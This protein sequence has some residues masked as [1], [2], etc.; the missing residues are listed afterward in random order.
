MVLDG[1]LVG[2]TGTWPGLIAGVPYVAGS[3][4]GVT[5]ANGTFHYEAGGTIH[6]TLA[7]VSTRDAAGAAQLSPYQLAASG[8]CTGSSELD[9]LLQLLDSLDADGDLTNGIALGPQSGSPIALSALTDTDL[10]ARVD[11]LLPGRAVTLAGTAVDNFI[12]QFDAE[13][14]SEIGKDTFTGATAGVRS[15][16]CAYDGMHWYFSWQYGL[17]RDDLMFNV[18]KSNTVAIPPALALADGSNHIGGIDVL[19]GTLYAPVEDGSAYKHPYIVAYDTTGLTSGNTYPLSNTMLTQGVP[20]VAV[21]GPRQS[22]Y[23]AQWDPT[24]AILVHDLATV[25][26][27][28]SINLSTAIGRV[29]GAKVFETMLYAST[30]NATKDIFKIN[31]ETGTV[32][33]LFSV[34]GTGIEEEDVCFDS[35]GDMHTQADISS[36]ASV[37]LR[38]HHRTRDP[39]RKTLC[40]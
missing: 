25:T 26:Y 14:W 12:R 11:A 7:G 20:W 39:L 21:D 34:M 29:Q 13:L 27:Q 4:S 18:Q 35:S 38:H 5:D 8:A 9:H 22:L 32:L 31:L 2:G 33:N 6:F 37:E 15:Q 3:Q 17:E 19:N 28:R 40:P 30:D 1:Q 10:A 24:P 36:A 16:G 23:V